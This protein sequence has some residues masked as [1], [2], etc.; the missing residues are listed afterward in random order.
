MTVDE[1]EIQFKCLTGWRP[2]PWQTSLW[3]EMVHKPVDQW[4]DAVDIPTGLGKTHVITV[5]YL[6]WRA[7]SDADTPTRLPRRLV[8]VVN[9]RTVQPRPVAGGCC[10]RDPY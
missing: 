9:R 3:E 4:P 7:T 1:F 5:W 10:N 6:A 2:F 8:Y